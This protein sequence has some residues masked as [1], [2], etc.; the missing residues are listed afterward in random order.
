MRIFSHR[1]L[2]E[3]LDLSVTHQKCTIHICVGCSQFDVHLLSS[4]DLVGPLGSW[5]DHGMSGWSGGTASDF[6]GIQCI[7]NFGIVCIIRPY[8]LHHPIRNEFVDVHLD[9]H[10]EDVAPGINSGDF[11]FSRG[12]LVR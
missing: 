2:S 7:F 1:S 5:L 11:E 12:D 4:L 9:F 8:H 6:S 10:S 3:H